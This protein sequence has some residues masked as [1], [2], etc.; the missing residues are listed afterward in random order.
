MYGMPE[1]STRMTPQKKKFIIS[2]FRYFGPQA[3][4]GVVEVSDY[5]VEPSYRS[6]MTVTMGHDM[7]VTQNEG[8]YPSQH[9]LGA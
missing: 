5:V 2:E 7:L 3:K 9:E 4:K 1:C 8:G 6:Q